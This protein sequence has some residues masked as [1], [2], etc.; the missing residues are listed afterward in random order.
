VQNLGIVKDYQNH[1][2]LAGEAEFFAEERY[3]MEE[4][5]KEMFEK[6]QAKFKL[7]MK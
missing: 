1:I 2:T 3:V 5:T 6:F 4:I 7:E